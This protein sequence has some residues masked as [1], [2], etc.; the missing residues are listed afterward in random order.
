MKKKYYTEDRIKKI[1]DECRSLNDEA[2]LPVRAGIYLDNI[3]GIDIDRACDRAKI[4]KKT[5]AVRRKH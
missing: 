2:T 3:E 5:A 4:A 1:F